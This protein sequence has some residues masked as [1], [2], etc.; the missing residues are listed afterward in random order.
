MKR[1][2]LLIIPQKLIKEPVVYRLSKQFP[3]TFNIRR[4]KVTDKAGEMVLELEADE[5]VLNKAIEWLRAQNIRVEPVTG[6]VVES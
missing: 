6:D 2:L 5:P 4:A 3:V 1:P